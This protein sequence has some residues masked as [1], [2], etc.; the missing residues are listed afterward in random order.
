ML[1]G[2]LELNNKAKNV[3]LLT[4]CIK[5]TISIYSNGMVTAKH[6]AMLSSLLVMVTEHAAVLVK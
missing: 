4:G 2:R 3:A 5:S 6:D 1:T